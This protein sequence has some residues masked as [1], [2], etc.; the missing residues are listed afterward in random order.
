MCY[1]KWNAL[2][3]GAG[4]GACHGL[5]NFSFQGRHWTIW[6]P[7]CISNMDNY[8]Q[9]PSHLLA[10]YLVVISQRISPTYSNVVCTSSTE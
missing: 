6:H 4:Y 9:S 1:A 10:D 7:G 2:K 8:D 5:Q 3:C